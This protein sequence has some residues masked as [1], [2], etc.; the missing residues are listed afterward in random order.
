MSSPDLQRQIVVGISDSLHI[1]AAFRAL[2]AA[3]TGRRRCWLAAPLIELMLER[4]FELII[5]GHRA[6]GPEGKHR[7][8]AICSPRAVRFNQ[9]ICWYGPEYTAAPVVCQT[10]R[11]EARLEHRRSL[12]ACTAAPNNKQRDRGCT[13]DRAGEIVVCCWEQ[14]RLTEGWNRVACTGPAHQPT[15]GSNRSHAPRGSRC[16]V[17]PSSARLTRSR[18]PSGWGLT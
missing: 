10:H 6:I 8:L 14:K 3:A 16:H 13:P 18:V 1:S 4:L 7:C 5:K 9:G 11:N 12:P 15:W 17:F 2:P